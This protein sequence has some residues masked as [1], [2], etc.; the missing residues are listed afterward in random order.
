[1]TN[2]PMLPTFLDEE[3]IQAVINITEFAAQ[4]FLRIMYLCYFQ[5]PHTRHL[6][7]KVHEIRVKSSLIK[8]P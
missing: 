3:T 6:F 2:N 5:L 4:Y 7:Q 1:M 8:F